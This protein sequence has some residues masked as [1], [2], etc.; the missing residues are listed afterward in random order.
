[1]YVY[2]GGEVVELT[3]AEA[4]ARKEALNAEQAPA[5]PP[6]PEERLTILEQTK[7]EQTDVDELH[8]ALN[9][10]LTGVTE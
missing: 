3:P 2:R 10:I 6:T 4:A 1:M 9:M 7:A 5:S 8:E